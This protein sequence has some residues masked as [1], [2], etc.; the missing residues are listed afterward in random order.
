MKP[1]HVSF[2]CNILLFFHIEKMVI[3]RIFQLEIV[4]DM[5][6]VER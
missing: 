5:V 2:F 1:T 3:K 4:I 6:K